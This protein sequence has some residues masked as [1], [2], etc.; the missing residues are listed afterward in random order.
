[1][2]TADGAPERPELI[3][4]LPPLTAIVEGL[5]PF[6]P[7]ELVPEAKRR[8]VGELAS[9]LPSPWN[10]LLFECRLSS[11][12]EQ[13]D[14]Q[15]CAMDREGARGALARALAR[16]VE[17]PS[18]GTMRPLLA[19]WSGAKTGA[20]GAIPAVWLEWDDVEGRRNDPFMF[21]IVDPGYLDYLSPFI[22]SPRPAPI[23]QLSALASG[24]LDAVPRHVSSA[25]QQ[26]LLAHC[27]ELLPADGRLFSLAA[28]PQRGHHQIQVVAALP[29]D[30]VPSWL[31]RIRWPGDR[32]ALDALL[33][34]Q[35]TAQGDR[36][37][38]IKLTDALLPSLAVDFG[39]LDP[40][41]SWGSLMARLVDAGLADPVKASACLRWRGAGTLEIPGA[42]WPLSV[43]RHPSV[44]VTAN[45][46]GRLE[47]K[48]YLLAAVAYRLLS[49]E[50]A[51]RE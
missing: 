5:A 28:A 11:S 30:K 50:R 9:E 32:A 37:V 12:S 7:E 41:F 25:Q 34:W 29:H 14:F 24:W 40:G 46:D 42:A 13:V 22:P 43:L 26:A 3:S 2:I 49:P 47:A 48:G 39:P 10:V 19:R 15:V 35:G 4:K 21:P 8:W 6:I 33:G 44:K 38:Y 18:L 16:P 1:V 36:C 51:L 17:Y 27:A 23:S 20:F 45:P 31:D